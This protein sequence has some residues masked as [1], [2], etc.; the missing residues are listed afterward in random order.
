MTSY[1][2]CGTFVF[3]EH[4]KEIAL[5]KENYQAEADPH[6]KKRALNMIQRALVKVQEIGDE[7]LQIVAQI[8]DFIE[9][10]SRQLE[11]DLE[12]LGMNISVIVDNP[13]LNIISVIN[14][15]HKN[16]VTDPSSTLTNRR[17]EEIAIVQKIVPAPPKT[18][19]RAANSGGST[20]HHQPEEKTEP[21]RQ[22]AKRQRRQRTHQDSVSRDDEKKVNK[23]LFC[24]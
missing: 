22:G 10:R 9:N 11:Q 18:T 3:L 23:F 5:Y 6:Q 12:N 24:I 14:H 20:P 16:Y 7:K 19:A 15:Q 13:D 1:K 2:L 21:V 4:M 17:E 8:V